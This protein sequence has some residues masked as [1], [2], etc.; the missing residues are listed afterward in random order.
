MLFPLKQTFQKNWHLST[1]HVVHLI[2]IVHSPLFKN[3]SPF[4]F[5]YNKP[6]NLLDLKNF[7]CLLFASN[8]IAHRTKFDTCAQKTFF[9]G[10]QN[11][12]KG[13]LLYN[14]HSHDF[15]VSRN[16]IFYEEVFPFHQN[17]NLTHTSPQPSSS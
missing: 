12:E 7:G 8:L 4:Q 11:G 14:M 1:K 10:F 15:L 17:N 5:L 3:N 16:A 13:Y 2:N 6:P 9:L